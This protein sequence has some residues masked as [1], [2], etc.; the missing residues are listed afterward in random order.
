M[1]NM[2]NIYSFKKNTNIYSLYS[3]QKKYLTRYITF[4]LVEIILHIFFSNDSRFFYIL[5][6]YLVNVY[7]YYL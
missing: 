3:F 1:V 6:N 7:F 4:F 2:F 5:Q